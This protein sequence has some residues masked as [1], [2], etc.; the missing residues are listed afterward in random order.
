MKI[1]ICDD[2]LSHRD[3]LRPFV[4]EFFHS[5]EISTDIREYSSGTD[6]LDSEENF[7][8][9][10]LDIEL[11]DMSGIEI[12]EILKEKNANC[13][14]IVVTSYTDYLDAAMDLHVIR[15]LKKPVE[16]KRVYSALEKALREMNENLIMLSTKD[17]QIIRVRSRDIIYVEAN[18]KAVTVCTNKKI[19]TV[20]ESLKKIKTMLTASIFAVP[21]NSFIVNMNYISKFKREEITVDLPSGEIKIQISNRK[22]PEFKRRFLEFIGEGE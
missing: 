2:V 16:Q 18:L 13:I 22:Q 15:F 19:Y 3:T 1:A 7:D 12:A 14:I 21:H 6:I 4:I 20:R 17:N 9:V 10:F 8:I 11:G 5:K